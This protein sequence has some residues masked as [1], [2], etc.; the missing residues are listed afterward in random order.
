MAIVGIAAS[1]VT[2]ML[3]SVC[4]KMSIPAFVS[5]LSCIIVNSP[6]SMNIGVIAFTNISYS[7]GTGR[8]NGGSA[9]I[10][11]DML[12]DTLLSTVLNK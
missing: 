5:K 2:V 11:L 9:K 8:A 6:M 3:D 12:L 1:F 7:D 4:Q 10:M